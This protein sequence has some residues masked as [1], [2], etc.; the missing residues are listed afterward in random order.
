[1]LTTS[2]AWAWQLGGNGGIS[3]LVDGRSSE[4]W[5]NDQCFSTNTPTYTSRLEPYH[6]SFPMVQAGDVWMRRWWSSAMA[7]SGGSS[8]NQLPHSKEGT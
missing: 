7:F 5:K 4:R 3:S 8:T 1:M 6:N 2:R